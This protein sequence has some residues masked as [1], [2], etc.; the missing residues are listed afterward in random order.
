MYSNS[1]EA[2]S[3]SESGNEPHI[4]ENLNL[5]EIGAVREIDRV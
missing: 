3:A 5:V 2:S 4:V 1:D